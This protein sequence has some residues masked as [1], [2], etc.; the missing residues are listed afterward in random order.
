MLI[1]GITFSSLLF[2]GDSELNIPRTS[3]EMRE[4]MKSD[5]VP[6]STCGVVTNVRELATQAEAKPT[7]DDPYTITAFKAT[8][9][10]PGAN[11]E[12]TDVLKLSKPNITP[13]SRWQVTIRYDNGAYVAIE[14]DRQPS[15]TMGD[16]VQV[17]DNQIERQ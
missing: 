17:T 9:S 16:R 12:V 1:V 8:R 7:S 3:A 6:C 5:N 13:A 10:A 14:Q 4:L 15:V 11:I 2:A